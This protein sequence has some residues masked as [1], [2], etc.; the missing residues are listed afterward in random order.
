MNAAKGI[1]AIAGL[2]FGVGLILSGMTN[3]ANILA[4]LDVA[5]HWDPRLA[6]VMAAAVLTAIPAFAYARRHSSTP[7]GQPFQ[8]PPSRTLV[9]ARL[10]IG[11]TIFGIGWGLSGLCPGPSLVLAGSGNPAGL[12][13]VAALA[14]GAML[15]RRLFPA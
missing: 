2:V 6:F 12:I 14:A 11:A 8:L 4:F 13:F 15:S 7:S 1:A 10:V 3:P 9:T 5:G